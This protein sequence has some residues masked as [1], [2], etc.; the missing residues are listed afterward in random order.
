[1]SFPGEPERKAPSH[2]ALPRG[3]TASR[4][5]TEDPLDLA[6]HDLLSLILE[7]G[8][9]AERAHQSALRLLAGLGRDDGRGPLR[10]IGRARACELIS[11]GGITPAAAAR[12]VASIELGKRFT[13][14]PVAA[15]IRVTTPKQ[16]FKRFHKRLRDLDQIEY[17]VLV[18]GRQ[19]VVIQERRV[20]KGTATT[21]IVHPR[22]VF[23]PAVRENALAV[24]LIHNDPTAHEKATPR[25]SQKILTARLREAGA[26]I[27]IELWDH[28]IIGE[29]GY[30]SLRESGILFGDRPP[31]ERTRRQRRGQQTRRAA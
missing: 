22:D 1:M 24:V 9:G 31:A 12:L 15:R 2:R 17:W 11:V 29:T 3:S 23:A 7:P 8:L 14:E 25:A 13:A 5:L 6:L 4:L 10:R 30:L 18:L 27:G 20:S 26:T 16:V 19:N 21:A 28:I